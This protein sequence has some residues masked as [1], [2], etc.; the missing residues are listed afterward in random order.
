MDS[1]GII[2]FRISQGNDNLLVKWDEKNYNFL[3]LSQFKRERRSIVPSIRKRRIWWEPVPE[4]AGYVI[5]VSKERN[6]FEPS[7]FS[8]GATTGIISKVVTGK[9]DL[10]IPDEWP[11]FP[12]EP[13]AYYIG[14]T[15][16]DDVGNQSDPF[17]SQGV[18]KF[19]SPLPPSNGGIESL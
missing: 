16:Q 11:E 14:I 2:D 8:W 1:R 9:T 10:I 18:F 5:Y 13:G 6:I 3:K 19:T 12:K 17:L 15:S 4:A 7:N